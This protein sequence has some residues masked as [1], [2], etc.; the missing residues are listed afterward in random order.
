[1]LKSMIN[2]DLSG[3]KVSLI[4][5][6][7]LIMLLAMSGN[8]FAAN[9]G[10]GFDGTDDYVTADGVCS[11]LNGSSTLSVECW[12]KPTIR[13]HYF[14][15]FNTSATV[16]WADNYAGNII[17]LG[18]SSSGYLR[19]HYGYADDSYTQTDGSTQLTA[20][21]WYHI[22]FTIDASNNAIVYL[23]GVSEITK[24]DSARRPGAGS[25]DRLSFAQEWDG[26][27]ASANGFAT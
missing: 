22:A 5:G 9:N 19:L 23:N 2:P 18:I 11:T 27:S 16:Q 15:A 3:K 1:M 4:L 10:L 17:L 12:I 20:D 24:S 21:T 13:Y 26:Y 8:L 6:M 14:L 25:G 7:M